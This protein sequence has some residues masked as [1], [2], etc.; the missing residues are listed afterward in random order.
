MQTTRELDHAA[1]E[2]RWGTR[3][4]TDVAV[5]FVAMPATMGIG[6][7]VN[8]SLTGAFMETQVMLRLLSLVYLQPFGQVRDGDQKNRL[9][10]SVVRQTSLGVG[11]EWCD[12]TASAR[13]Y[14]QL[15]AA[16]PQRNDV[17]ADSPQRNDVDA[18]SPQHNDVNPQNFEREAR[19]SGP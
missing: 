3:K 13:A 1:M 12:S 10:A 9:V 2:H 11:L 6:R 4:S 8:I 15:D 17:N 18:A 16:S 5:R 7:V 19:C 14:A